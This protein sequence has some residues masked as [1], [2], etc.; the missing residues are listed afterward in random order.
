MQNLVSLDVLESMEKHGVLANDR[1]ARLAA[2]LNRLR[3]EAQLEK[4]LALELEPAMHALGA[5][6]KRQQREEI[7]SPSNAP[8]VPLSDV[9]LGRADDVALVFLR[10]V[11]PPREWP[12]V[13]D[14]NSGEAVQ[15]LPPQQHCGVAFAPSWCRDELEQHF[16]LHAL[17]TPTKLPILLIG[18]AEEARDIRGFLL[19]RFQAH[20]TEAEGLDFLSGVI[21][22]T[23]SRPLLAFWYDFYADDKGGAVLGYGLRENPFRRVLEGVLARRGMIVGS[24]EFNES[25][26]EGRKLF[27][28]ESPSRKAQ[29]GGATRAHEGGAHAL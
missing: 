28:F 22:D 8:A 10:R 18:T 4:E 11:P 25:L 5:A 17:F 23:E 9:P 29:P 21:G 3:S 24:R 7:P 14:P 16:K 15:L 20:A 27:E 6:L 13:A 1:F 19:G 12:R 2:E 26:D